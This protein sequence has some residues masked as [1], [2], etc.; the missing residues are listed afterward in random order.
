MRHHQLDE[1]LD[2]LRE[3]IAALRTTSRSL[4]Q[5]NPAILQAALL[6]LDMAEEELRTL[7]EQ[8]APADDETRRAFC[9]LLDRLPSPL[10]LL[11]EHGV[12]VR[13]NR[14]AAELLGAPTGYL[15]GKPFA[16]YVDLA[17][18]AAFRSHLAALVRNGGAPPLPS[19]LTRH[20]FC[21]DLTQM[22]ALLFAEQAAGEVGLLRKAAQLLTR[23]YA[24]LAIIDRVQGGR[25]RRVAV[26]GVHSAAELAAVERARPVPCAGPLLL[27][28]LGD[29]FALGRTSAGLPLLT[30]LG[31]GSAVRVP[32][33]GE[34][35]LTLVRRGD[36]AGFRRD[37]LRLSE[38]LA[39]HLALAL[40]ADRTLRVRTRSAHL[41]QTSLLPRRLPEVDGCELASLY[42]PA[43]EGELVGG[44]FYDAFR[45][46]GGWG[47]VLGDVCGK[48]EEAATVTAMA[49]HGIRA[50]AIGCDDPAQW[51]AG[52]NRT[53]MAYDDSDRFVTAA[54][55][56]AQ[57]VSG[58]VRLRL[59]LAGH[60]PPLVREADGMVRET[61][62]GGLPLGLFDDPV[63]ETC[64]LTLRHGDALVL[65]SDG[66]TEC[67]NPTGEL[68]GVRRLCT[69]VAAAAGEAPGDIVTAVE[70]DL[71]GFSTGRGDDTALLVLRVAD[72]PT[73]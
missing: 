48:G 65:H 27:E 26:A 52:V 50:L 15:T 68:Y 53:L 67:R 8:Q 69:T 30:L 28:P 49:R 1:S 35:T 46:A 38:W 63:Y 58:G 19:R 36:R 2:Q 71:R 59:A 20:G 60:L 13:A 64:E 37:D 43:G 9:D 22:T 55:A 61:A 47:L 32:V 72:C 6:E 62:G 34:G 16:A 4:G 23:S 17:H 70:K 5:S 25:L 3:R 21:V 31:A 12:V 14:A 56:H 41:L 7:T 10:F 57:P 29:E 33:E 45:S 39:R 54:V 51:L 66:V 73:F 42:L 40:L 11:D 18:R 44:D 24:D